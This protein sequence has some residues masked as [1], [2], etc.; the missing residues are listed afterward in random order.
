ML[1]KA[2]MLS[3]NNLITIRLTNTVQIA[4]EIIVSKFLLSFS[5]IDNP[6]L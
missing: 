1:I 6:N 3:V 4:L 5:I 2:I